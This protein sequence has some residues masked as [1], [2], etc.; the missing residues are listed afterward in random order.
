MS[1]LELKEKLISRILQTESRTILNE[2]FR[3]LE[4]EEAGPEEV[5]LTP[6]QKKAI[7][8]G[9]ADIENGRFLT[10]E[11]ADKEIRQWLNE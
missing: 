10:N 5:K 9:Q 7:L 11:Q 4:L 2:I 8:E 6:A 3:L 1:T